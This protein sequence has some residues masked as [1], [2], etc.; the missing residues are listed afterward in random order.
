MYASATAMIKRFVSYC[1]RDQ[2]AF[3]ATGLNAAHIFDLYSKS[4]VQAK[5][6]VDESIYFLGRGLAGFINIFNPDIIIIGGG[7]A[8]AGDVFLNGIRKVAFQ[9]AMEKPAENVKIE[10]ALLGNRAGFLGALAFAF[11]Q[12]D[13]KKTVPLQYRESRLLQMKYRFIINPRS[14]P[15]KKALSL[16][17]KIDARF[18]QTDHIFEFAFTTGPGDATD[19]ARKSADEQCDIVVGVGGDGTVNEVATGLIHSDTALG[20]IPMGS[21][22]GVARSL[23]LPLKFY[24]CLDVLSKPVFDYIDSGEVNGH[25]FFGICGIGFDARVGYKFQHFG[26]RGPIPYFVIGVKEF[27]N[28]I[29]QKIVLHTEDQEIEI[30]PLLLA[31]ANTS[32]YGNGALIAPMADPKDGWFEICYLKNTSLFK[33]LSAVRRLFNGTIDKIDIYQHFQARALT[34]SSGADQTIV[35]LDGEPHIFTGDLQIRIH[36]RSLKVALGQ[37][38]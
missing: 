19:L 6:T 34:I 11:E 33:S 9:Y 5:Q 36:P 24:P 7:V 17:E 28:Y 21:G 14:G 27:L 4:H 3:N 12:A 22:N 25:N 13:K 26:I 2:V 31:I 1:Q 15:R 18:R 16:V 30:S 23:K 8:E 38:L 20:I 29:P 10:R 35:H 32:Q 37:P